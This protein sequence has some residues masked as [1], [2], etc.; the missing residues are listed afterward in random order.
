MM[1]IQIHDWWV[2][3]ERGDRHEWIRWSKLGRGPQPWY[4]MGSFFDLGSVL[5]WMSA[6]ASWIFFTPVLFENIRLEGAGMAG[7]DPG[8]QKRIFWYDGEIMG[9]SIIEWGLM[10]RVSPIVWKIK[11][12][13]FLRDFGPITL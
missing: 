2:R 8:F 13:P 10:I 12:S 3:F 4:Y 11:Y 9:I 6:N 1:L 5:A 7:F